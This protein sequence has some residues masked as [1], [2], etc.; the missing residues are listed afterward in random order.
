MEAAAGTSDPP[1]RWADR[2]G[3]SVGPLDVATFERSLDLRW[4][5]TSY[6]GVTALVHAGP[7]VDS[8]PEEG[9]T[10][11]E[12]LAGTPAEVLDG[13][14][15]AGGTVSD[16][17]TSLR[18]VVSPWSDLPAGADMGTLVHRVLQEVDFA[19]PDLDREIARFVAATPPPSGAEVLPG[20]L[21]AALRA[22]ITTSL[23]PLAGGVAL[24]DVSPGDRLNEMW[25]ELPVAGGDAPDD[26]G[27]V[28][29]G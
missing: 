20:R 18:G 19:S 24:H 8:E 29:D 11:D 15:M 27:A 5:R 23:G 7:E 26:Q 6:S 4:R 21:G 28:A 25:F 17:E 22:S 10:A 14:E 3:Q 2:T 16:E 12:P 1:A 13:G 9:G